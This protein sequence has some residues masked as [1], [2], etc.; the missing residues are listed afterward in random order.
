MMLRH[1]PGRSDLN[2]EQ[3]L[4]E[5]DTKSGIRNPELYLMVYKTGGILF[6]LMQII[7]VHAKTQ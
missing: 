2:T 1:I 6:L 7:N 4:C 3:L 5:P